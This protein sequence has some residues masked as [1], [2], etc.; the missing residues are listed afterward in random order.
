MCVGNHGQVLTS[1]TNDALSSSKNHNLEKSN[2][3]ADHLK[4]NILST[5]IL[6]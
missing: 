5:T 4:E 1:E 2:E 6:F 3:D